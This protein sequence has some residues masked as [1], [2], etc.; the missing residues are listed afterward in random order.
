MF[1]DCW[2]PEGRGGPENCLAFV[3]IQRLQAMEEKYL[4]EG[5]ANPTTWL[6]GI[7]FRRSFKGGG[8][9]G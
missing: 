5:G 7:V 8:D 1:R 9:D 3:V 4:E 6:G 2:F